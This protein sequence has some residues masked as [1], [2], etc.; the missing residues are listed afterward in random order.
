M[1]IIVPM[2]QVPDVALNI[3]V[4]DGAV[5]EEGLSYVISS[6]DETALEAALQ[7]TEDVGGEVTLLTI[8]PDKA[9]ESLRKGL[10]MGAH[11]AIHVKYND[12]KQTDSFAYAKILQKVL[13]G[14]DYDLILTGKQAQDTDAGLTAP[15]LAEFLGLP[16]VTNIIRF[17]DVSEQNITL[18]RKGDHAT[19]VLEM[20]LPGVVTVNDSLNEPRLA[21]MRGIM[22]AKKKPLEE[23][24]LDAIGVSAEMNGA[25]GSMTEILQFDKPESRKEGKSF[26]GD[27]TDTVKQAMD[28][29][30]SEAKFLA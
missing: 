5:V 21:S 23:I 30:V 25:Q 26:E 22:M 24:E 29:L 16:Q 11:K 2:K 13:E 28:L 18:Y 20:E 15:M 19:E 10:A 3:K 12:A 6:W 4:K 8:G 14:R 9:A 17:S 1:E 7:I 27:E